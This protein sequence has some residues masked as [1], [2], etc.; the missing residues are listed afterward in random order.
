MSLDIFLDKQYPVVTY[1]RKFPKDAAL[2]ITIIDRDCTV[3]E[4]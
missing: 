3:E 2:L 1:C 4:F